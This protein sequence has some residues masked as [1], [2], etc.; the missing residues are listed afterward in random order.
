MGDEVWKSVPGLRVG[1]SVE[2]A[3]MYGVPSWHNTA[4]PPLEPGA[5][6]WGQRRPQPR[7]AGL[8]VRSSRVPAH[9]GRAAERVLPWLGL[10]RH[11]GAEE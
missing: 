2:E 4:V 5:Q 8:T 11:P 10:L 1:L 6:A 3:G 9:A 7:H